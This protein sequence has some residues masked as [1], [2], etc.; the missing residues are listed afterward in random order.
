M[1][2]LENSSSFLKPA[3]L[4]DSA[5]CASGGLRPLLTSSQYGVL[6]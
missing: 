5:A 6:Y 4:P 3:S 1:P 2:N